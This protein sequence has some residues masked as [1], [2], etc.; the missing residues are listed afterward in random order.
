MDRYELQSTQ[1]KEADDS[2]A[3]HRPNTHVAATENRMVEPEELVAAAGN[4]RDTDP[5][6][7]TLV[8]LQ[9][10]QR[11]Q[12]QLLRHLLQEIEL[13][14]NTQDQQSTTVTKLDRRLRRA[15]IWRLGWLLIRWLLFVAGLGSI[16]YFIG[17]ERIATFWER[18]IWLLT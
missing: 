4:N 7:R 17:V 8:I 3:P 14:K 10:Q 15:R 2:L 16:L 6:L 13:L 9:R 5:V 18:L 11:E 1:A 12:T